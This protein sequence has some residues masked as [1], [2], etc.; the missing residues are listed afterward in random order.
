ML[1][2]KQNLIETI[3]GGNPDR[4]VNQ[5]EAFTL[6]RATPFYEHNPNPKRGELNVVNAWGIAK[7]F[8]EGTP[9]P[10]PVH[11]DEHVV[12]KDITRWKDYVTVPNI[13]FSEEE[14]APYVE[15]ASKIDR[16]ECFV[17]G[18]VAPGV[19]EQC[20]YLMEISKCLMNFYLEPDAMHEIIEM[21]TE[22]ELLYAAEMCK[23]IKPDALLHHDDWG[24]QKS[25]FVS[26]EMFKEFFLEPYKR[27]YGYYK[28]HGVEVVIHH[29]DSYGATLIP[30][31]IDMGIDIWQGCMRSNNIPEMLRAGG[32]KLSFMCGIDNADVDRPGWTPELA[33]AA[34]KRAVSDGARHYFIPCMTGGGPGS[35]YPGVYDTVSAAISRINGI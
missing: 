19:F 1:T 16:N 18:F 33:E 35:T 25:T 34:V 3:R 20:H 32:G 23:Y 10:F 6:Q 21:I 13:V 15:E 31:M 24:S 7:S 2:K 8:P 27:I 5:F 30:Y 12:I 4:Y 28:N 17:T 9:G 22:W 11:D 14:W 26:P 29:S